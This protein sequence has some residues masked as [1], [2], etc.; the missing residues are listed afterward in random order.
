MH[1][2]HPVIGINRRQIGDDN[3][4]DLNSVAEEEMSKKMHRYQNL[5]HPGALVDEDWN[6]GDMRSCWPRHVPSPHHC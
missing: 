4:V 1:C 3:L 2:H 6:K 5:N